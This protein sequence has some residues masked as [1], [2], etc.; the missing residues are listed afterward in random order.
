MN[1]Q[2]AARYKIKP[3]E[4]LE[5]PNILV[6]ELRVTTSVLSL[7]NVNLEQVGRERTSLLN[8]HPI[9]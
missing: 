9:S 8:V 2:V 3:L 1:L 5:A 4:A 7:M 6:H